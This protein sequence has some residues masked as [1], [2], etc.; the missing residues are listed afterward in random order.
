MSCI[1]DECLLQILNC[2]DFVGDS[3]EVHFG[4]YMC[5]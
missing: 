4:G 3:E 2:V 5:A 1:I